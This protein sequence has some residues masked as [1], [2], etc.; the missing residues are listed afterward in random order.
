[1]PKIGHLKYLLVIINHLINW[2]EAIPLLSATVSNITKVFLENIIP[3]FRLV[4]NIDSD[5]G[6]HFTATI[7]KELMKILG[8]KW[9]YH[10]PGH[11]PSSGKIG[12][13]N[14]TLKRHIMK[15]IL[16]TKL[17]WTK[18]LPIAL[19]RIRTAPPALRHLPHKDIGI[20][21]YEMLYVLPYLDTNSNLP[22]METKDQFLKNYILGL[23]STLLSLRLQGLLAQSQPG[24]NLIRF[25][26]Y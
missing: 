18:C 9:V 17:P 23:S 13:M 22:T 4:E 16:E 14:Q 12:R 25:L 8:I 21:P 1:M 20:S 11:P 10:S 5:N 7:T 19:F 24:K 3:G 15:L 26:L 2:V 6:S